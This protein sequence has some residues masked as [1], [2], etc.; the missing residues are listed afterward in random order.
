MQNKTP[1]VLIHHLFAQQAQR[2][3]NQSAL[4]FNDQ[5]ITY[6]QLNES[7]NQLA[8]YL[9][10]TGVSPGEAVGLSKPRS[11]EMVVALLAILKCGAYYVALDP[12]YP[13]ERLSFMVEDSQLNHLVT[14]ASLA[15]SIFSNG[16]FP[17]THLITPETAQP[18]VAQQPIT[19]PQLKQTPDD[20]L[21]IL[22]TSGSTGT[23]KGVI[24]HHRGAI[25]R[26]QWMWDVYPFAK[27][28]VCCQKTTLNFVDSVW[29][30]WGPLLKGIPTVLIPDAIIADPRQLVPY[31]AKHGVTRLVLVPSLLKVMLDVF[32]NLGEQL[33]SLS[34]W[35]TSGETLPYDLFKRF[36]DAVPKATLLNIYGS[37]EI[38]ADATCFD[39]STQSIAD[40]VSIGTPIHNLTVYILDENRQPVPDGER[41][42]LYVSGGGV[43]TGYYNRPSLT[44]E[45]FM[46]DPFVNDGRTR[47]FKTGDFGRLLPDG[48]IEYLGRADQQ[49]KIRGVRLELGEIEQVLLKN[50][51]VS[52]AVL[53]VT[54][55]RGE[56]QLI[57]YIVPKQTE[58][59]SSSALRK[60]CATKLPDYMVPAT[61]VQLDAFPLTPNGKIDRQKLPAARQKRP[62]LD[63]PFVPPQTAREK[64]IAAIWEDLLWV[65]GIGVRDSFFELGGDSLLVVALLERLRN[66]LDITL[67]AQDIFELSTIRAILTHQQS[68]TISFDIGPEFKR[69]PDHNQ[70]QS[71]SEIAI[72]G[73]SGRFP[74]AKTTDALWENLINGVNGLRFLTDE[75][76][77]RVEIEYDELKSNP[78][79]V[80]ATGY[81][82]DVNLFDAEFFGVKRGEARLLDPQQRLWLEVAWEALENAGYIP[83]KTEQ[84]IGVYAGS[85]MNSYL[86]YNLLPNR[87]SLDRFVRM[88]TP[89]ALLNQLTND[90]DYLPTRTA[91]LLNLTGPA[92]NV[93]TACSTSLVAVSMACD[94]ILNGR[95]DLAL[96]G[97]VSIFLPQERGYIYQEGGILSKDGSCRPFDEQASGTVFASGAGCVL[98]KRLDQAI[99][100][101]DHIYAVIKGSAI[102][103][104]GRDKASYTAP[105]IRGQ[106]DVIRQAQQNAGV[107]ADSISYVEAHATATPVGDPI[108]V[109]ALTRV[110]QQDGAQTQFCGLGSV[111][112]NI[113]HLDAAAGVAGLIKT[114]LALHH[115][116]IPPTLH[117]QKANGRID[118]N[119]S[120]FYIVDQPAAWPRGEKPRR[121]GISSFG[122]GGTNVHAILEEA[123]ASPPETPSR[124]RQLLL[125]SARSESAL[126]MQSENLANW[127]EDKRPFLPNV[128]YTLKN[129]RADFAHR[130]AIV[131]ADI[132]DAAEQLR[133]PKAGTQSQLTQAEP[134]LVMMFPGQGSQFVGMGRELY[135]SE[136]I[137]RETVD[138][139]AQILRPYL[140]LDLRDILYPED[141]QNEEAAHRLTQTELAQPA[142]FTVSYALAKTWQAWGIQPNKLVGHSVGEFVA[143]AL[144]GVFSLEDALKIIAKR[145]HL[146]QNLPSGSM[147]AVRL[148]AEELEPFLGN[149]VTLAANN[150]PEICIVSGD[151]V[152]MAQFVDRVEAAGHD[153]IP[154]HT[155]HA[156]HSEMMDPILDDFKAVVAGANCSPPQL[157]I[158]STLT[159]RP[160]THKEAT[161][162]D[163]WANQLRHPVR[164]SSAVTHLLQTPNSVFLEAGP[165]KTLTA[166]VLQHGGAQTAVSSLGHPRKADPALQMMLH[167]VGQLWQAGVAIN[168]TQFYHRE[169]RRRIPLPTYPFERERFW[170]EPPQPAKQAAPQPTLLNSKTNINIFD[171]PPHQPIV[172]SINPAGVIT[173]GDAIMSRKQQITT[174]LTTLLLD[175]SG[176]EIAQ[177]AYDTSF[178]ELGFD[179]LLLTQVSSR[180]KKELKLN[181]RFRKFLEDVTTLN[182]L[183]AYCEAQLP[184]EA[185][186]E[187]IS[188]KAPTGHQP[189][190]SQPAI[191][192]LQMP[193]VKPQPSAGSANNLQLLF[194]QMSLQQNALMQMMQQ[195]QTMQQA[196]M[197]TMLGKTA[198]SNQPSSNSAIIEKVVEVERKRP[199]A[200]TKD[201][202]DTVN[203]VRFGPYKPLQRGEKG[204][205]T[206]QQQAYLDEFIG[207]LTKKTAASKA[208]AQQNRDVQADPRTVAGFR[209]DWKEI[210]Y[211]IATDRS[212]G[213]YLWD[214]DGNQYVDMTCGFGVH[215]FGHNPE[216]VTKAV[217]EQVQQGVELGPQAP[218]AG[219]VARLLRELTGME[220][221]SFCNTGSE[222]IMAALRMA[223]TIS[224]RDKVVYFSGD[225]HGVFDE[226][227][228]RSQEL[229]GE[230]HT[231]PAAP[232]ISEDSVSNTWILDYGTQASLDFIRENKDEI[233]AILIETVQS[234]YPENR[235]FEFVK[236]LRQLTQENE[237]ALVFDEV[238]TGFRVHQGGMQKI[239]GVKPDIA[240]YGKIIGG[241]YPIGVVA[242]DKKY[243]DCIDG[244]W[245][246]YG[247][248]SVPEVDLTFFAGTFVRHRVAMAAA[249]AVLTHLKEQGNQLQETLNERTAQ[250]AHELNCFFEVRGVP[251]KINHYSSWFR[252]EVAPDYRFG[253]LIFYHLI[254]KG[255]F[256]FTF[257]QN[258][259][260]STAHS[261]ADIQ[262]IIDAF[263]T[264]VIEMQEGGFLP[265]HP[266]T[267]EPIPMTTP[268]IEMWFPS[269]HS[270]KASVSLNES[271]DIRL[272]GTVRPTALKRAGETIL[273][274]HQGFHMRF[275][276]YMRGQVFDGKRRYEIP[277]LDFSNQPLEDAIVQ[278]DAFK[279]AQQETP[280]DLENGPLARVWLVKLAEETY[281]ML[282]YAYHIVFD[283][284]SSA[285]VIEE[286]KALY[287]GEMTN[288]AVL[289]PEPNR[290]EEYVE[291]A[292]DIVTSEEKEAIL[293]YWRQ[294]LDPLPKG[295]TIPADYARPEQEAFWGTSMFYAF[296]AEMMSHVRRLASH[297]SASS[298]AVMLAA[299]KATLYRM[300]N[301]EEFMV[302]IHT[303]GQPQAGL[304]NLVGHTVGTLPIRTKTTASMPFRDFVTYIK[305]KL[306]DGQE[307]Q[308]FTMGELLRD[309][310]IPHQAGDPWFCEI[311]FNLD[312]KISDTPFIGADST[313]REIH[314]TAVDWDLFL[315]LFE[316]G[317]LLCADVDYRTDLFKQSTI[318]RLLENLQNVVMSLSQNPDQT[319]GEL[320]L[321]SKADVEQQ[322]ISWNNTAKKW[323]ENTSVTQLIRAQAEKTPNRTAVK[324]STD[325]LTYQELEEASNQVAHYLMMRGVQPGDFVGLSLTRSV[326]MVV[327]LLGIIKTGGVYIP[328]DPEFPANRIHTIIED[329]GMA[330]YITESEWADHQALADTAVTILLDKIDHDLEDCPTHA[331]EIDLDLDTA[332]YTIYTSGS[333]GTP[334]GVKIPHS[335]LLNFLHSMT[336]QPGLAST[337]TLMSVT[338]LSF[339]IAALEIF[340][341]LINGAKLII[342]TDEKVDGSLLAQRLSEEQVTVMQATPAT[343]KMLLDSGWQGQPNLKMLCGGEA[344]PKSLAEQ[345]LALAGELWNMY[346]PTETTIWSSIARISAPDDITIGQ[347]IANTTMLILD[348][349]QK[350]LPVGMVGELYIGGAGVA[351]GY[352]NRPDLD[353]ERFVDNPL[354]EGKLF[355]TG[356]LAKYAHDGSIIHLGREDFQIKLRGYRIE[357]GEIEANLSRHPNVK[358]A[359]V[360]VQTD[361]ENNQFLVGY[362]VLHGG[363]P[364]A[365]GNEDWRAFLL[366]DLP[367]YMV[368]MAFV[369]M[370]HL[371]L[372]PNSKIDR[373]A[374]PNPIGKLQAAQLTPPQTE[375]ERE[376]ADMW[377]TLL[378]TDQV[379][380]ESDFFLLGGQSLLMLRMM[381]KIREQYAVELPLGGFFQQSKLH[382]LVEQVETAVWAKQNNGSSLQKPP[383]EREQFEI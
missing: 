358:Q 199:K 170:V 231:L 290:I 92:I 161:S 123:P 89:G 277:I 282:W 313:I 207:R 31:L 248:N 335:A 215:Y 352:H 234:R 44:A 319:M 366:A 53:A 84:R 230:L 203:K 363:I 249:K 24:G 263:K 304:L 189:I 182:D 346:G 380:L 127:L 1:S 303:A 112:S 252:I 284:W 25:N 254:E 150:A 329:S 72:I 333:S 314:K 125:L 154:L 159:G 242:G 376:L 188:P 106:V 151:D 14:T 223:R 280:F 274:R 157:P 332:V 317:D 37:S 250:F 191:E 143:A 186:A 226:A 140:R 246:Q 91:H 213:A 370:D 340:L 383:L 73:I 308:P 328:I 209:Q 236:Q 67:E 6:K 178:L 206:E 310:I 275:L 294:E 221:A 168:W 336:E 305:G 238:V 180:L 138:Q 375:M 16:R 210:V 306:L 312:R 374:L 133:Q 78:D 320:S 66:D 3:P 382:N 43:A 95:S 228:A 351:L 69:K 11:I 83:S 262:H 62:L 287:N 251:I 174:K 273:M 116:T 334:K 261:D 74:K 2:T 139:C 302:G 276:P 331:P 173:T 57:A 128:A 316:E 8:H 347:P 192:T 153:T 122:M 18:A 202:T 240:C 61:F 345:L 96:A 289:L 115:E 247:D 309:M 205:L 291:W 324:T 278:L 222:A 175:L 183:I 59:L 85:Y 283:G 65:S 245:W 51:A 255:V 235:P 323:S 56:K 185:F 155:S 341:P 36:Q 219:E 360:H 272:T 105:S 64:A 253:D 39:T 100:D 152:P 98:L 179:S 145:A 293:T 214:I 212:Q 142:I 50:T 167:A 297:Y 350:L 359:V 243:M 194:Q 292:N 156:F 285:V 315:N 79:Y 371:P 330:F 378:Q 190:G 372:T 259:F 322:L 42:E 160:L 368:P 134:S 52:Q 267:S 119:S 47:M 129:G 367:T 80:P 107:T 268:Q 63:T 146:M 118:F 93:Q 361:E 171:T 114:V 147:Y 23:P 299:F 256:V 218:L 90:K 45:R 321:L 377:Q 257:A 15:E 244:G 216:F 10:K 342:A 71:A 184:Q 5:E 88:Q 70:P 141:S 296:D 94:A 103:N 172:N 21:Y 195:Q 204:K 46:P 381:N 362:L 176:I 110:F 132:E 339:D 337:D 311:F 369:I 41:G 211:Q 97:G 355:R 48:N 364:T 260:L 357:L 279:R 198:V 131:T 327:T 12:K 281:S 76:L 144:A 343:W 295:L 227:L 373:N 149:G 33:P 344:L 233:A 271:F 201:S 270:D 9:L 60:Y 30:I 22:Y 104:D 239:Y 269:Q 224:E 298:F 81:L 68:T 301:R 208:L 196:L 232:G 82:D 113:G 13:T 58:P 130:R 353:A 217:I 109:T 34:L 365:M 379:G 193:R 187:P 265:G 148:A 354:G 348:K 162:P 102:N 29:E 117:Y 86:L 200:P 318:I 75:E 166:S 338:T 55:R 111:K 177:E 307:M 35:T 32:P 38:A 349:Q 126:Q 101:G 99:A 136:P 258:C 286:L 137:Y 164:F 7:S 28:E 54:E 87:E 163:Y 17:K 266:Q 19:R 237:I 49:V 135:E 120:P 26:F 288:T 241:G 124:P 165:G 169:E 229:K 181:I 197:Q 20:P 158:V 108:E 325:A 300:T 77:Q 27:G 220:R 40:K 264:S 356:D 4:I 225:Y 326:E 121:A